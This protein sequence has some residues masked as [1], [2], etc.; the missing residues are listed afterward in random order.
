MLMHAHYGGVQLRSILVTLYIKSTLQLETEWP[1][2]LY[3]KNTLQL[4]AE[5]PIN[6]S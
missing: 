3:K 1:M 5:W 2:T 6:V 4:E